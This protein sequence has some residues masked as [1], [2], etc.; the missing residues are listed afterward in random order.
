MGWTRPRAL[1]T[2]QVSPRSR[3][4]SSPQLR[5]DAPT[6]AG[7]EAGKFRVWVVIQTGY[8]PRRNPRIAGGAGLFQVKDESDQGPRLARSKPEA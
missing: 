3:Q 2:R 1:F 6:P 4:P 8:P 5:G 7:A